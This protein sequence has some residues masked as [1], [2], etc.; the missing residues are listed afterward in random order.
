MT[1]VF[2]MRTTR[3]REALAIELV[4]GLDLNKLP[5]V[6][7]SF[8]SPI[9]T[10]SSNHRSRTRPSWLAVDPHSCLTCKRITGPPGAVSM[11][12][13]QC[14]HSGG[15]KLIGRDSPMCAQPEQLPG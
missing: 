9:H 15:M 8:N 14:Q 7:I 1:C 12:Q 4:L 5:D 10:E 11:G 13:P 2:Q 3:L 6:D